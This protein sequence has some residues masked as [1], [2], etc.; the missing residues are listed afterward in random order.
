MRRVDFGERL[1]SALPLLFSQQPQ[2]GLKSAFIH[3][4]RRDQYPIPPL[5]RKPPVKKPPNSP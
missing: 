5:P 4:L 3:S 2:Q 1:L